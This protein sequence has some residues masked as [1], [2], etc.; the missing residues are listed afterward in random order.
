[1]RLVLGL[2][3]LT[4]VAPAFAAEVRLRSSATC[5]AAVVRLADVAEIEAGDLSLAAALAGIPLCPAPAEGEAK[6]L[7]QEDVR[8][9]LAISGLER[10]DVQVTGSEQVA[11]IVDRSRV[12]AA[13]PRQIGVSGVRQA[14]FEAPVTREPVVARQPA[15]RWPQAT[16]AAA[17]VKLIERG[18]SVN[19]LA[20]AAGVRVA[21]NG[22]AMQPGALGDTI[23]IELADTKEKIQGRIIA[24]QMIEVVVAGK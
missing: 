2:A 23:Q 9:L 10:T 8:Q 19:V 18:A 16:T 4:L 20:R 24:P 21:T 17:P 11:L 22:K 3:M 6:A 7:S 15:A 5:A 1:M 14:L 13:R 12:P